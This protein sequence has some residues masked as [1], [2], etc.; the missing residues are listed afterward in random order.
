MT[1]TTR[2]HGRCAVD[3]CTNPTRRQVI[4]AHAGRW[5]L[6][7]GFIYSQ[8]RRAFIGRSWAEACEEHHHAV[9]AAVRADVDDWHDQWTVQVRT[10]DHA[11]PEAGGEHEYA[12][13]MGTD[14][15]RLF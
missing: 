1:T 5:H 4:E 7:H 8:D 15:D 2:T 12:H 14:N 3:D 11:D 13:G 9:A 10:L 6:I